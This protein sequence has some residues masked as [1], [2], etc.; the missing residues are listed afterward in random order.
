M[1]RA[2]PGFAH[3]LR[4]LAC[5]SLPVQNDTT[6][7]RWV[8]TLDVELPILRHDEPIHLVVNSGVVA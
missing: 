7:C 6:L 8:K 1:L 3:S 5:Q 2:L 4:D